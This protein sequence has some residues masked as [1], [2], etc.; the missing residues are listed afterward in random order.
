LTFKNPA[1]IVLLSLFALFLLSCHKS[2]VSSEILEGETEANL[3]TEQ[4]ELDFIRDK[5]LKMSQNTRGFWEAEFIHGIVMIYI[6]AGTFC[7]KV[8]FFP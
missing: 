6:P 5:A 7:Q 8:S 2:S 3:R 1:I 4:E